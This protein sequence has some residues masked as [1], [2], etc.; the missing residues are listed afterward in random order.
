MYA[1]TS[2]IGLPCKCTVSRRPGPEYIVKSPPVSL[3]KGSPFFLHQRR[4]ERALRICLVID[5]YW[6]FTSRASR[7][8]HH[9]LDIG[10]RH[11]I[12]LLVLEFVVGANVDVGTPVFC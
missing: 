7:T 1:C 8:T 6:G 12:K 9:R 11:G 10:M 4:H 3:S 2:P 5:Q